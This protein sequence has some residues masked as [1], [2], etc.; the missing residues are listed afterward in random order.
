MIRTVGGRQFYVDVAR[1]RE[2]RPLTGIKRQVDPV[3]VFDQANSLRVA[4]RLFN[5]ESDRRT[6][7]QRIQFGSGFSIPTVE[8]QDYI[9]LERD[10]RFWLGEVIEGAQTAAPRHERIG[11]RIQRQRYPV[12]SLRKP[13]SFVDDP[14]HKAAAF[15]EHKQFDPPA[16]FGKL[17]FVRHI[18][19]V[20]ELY[21]HRTGVVFFG[22]TATPQQTA[23]Q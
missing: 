5:R 8:L 16:L 6:V 4:V 15:I 18:V 11:S 19:I 21:I 23:E 2:C 10:I 14:L 20:Y 22:K 12:T 3:R 13:A 7:P 17:V 1:S 9:L